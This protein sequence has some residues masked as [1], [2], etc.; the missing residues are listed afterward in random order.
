MGTVSVSGNPREMWLE[1]EDG[2]RYDVGAVPAGVYVLHAVFRDHRISSRRFMV[3][4]RATTHL[5]CDATFELCKVGDR[6]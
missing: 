4:P 1:R 3:R 6:P 2:V 5:R